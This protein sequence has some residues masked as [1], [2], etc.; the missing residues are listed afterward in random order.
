MLLP[1]LIPLIDVTFSTP[2]RFNVNYEPGVSVSE[3]DNPGSARQLVGE[4]AI[5][6]K[7]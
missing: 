5:L 3:A 4:A 2:T 7:S 1:N 6:Y